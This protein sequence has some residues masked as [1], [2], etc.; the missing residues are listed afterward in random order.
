MEDVY[1]T[2]GKTTTTTKFST[3]ETSSSRLSTLSITGRNSELGQH[4]HIL[5]TVHSHSYPT[6]EER[7]FFQ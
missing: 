4:L 5:Q 6:I 1:P 3:M 7:T 2:E